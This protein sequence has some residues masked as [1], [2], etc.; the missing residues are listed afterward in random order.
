LGG[1]CDEN[2]IGN[3]GESCGGNDAQLVRISVVYHDAMGGK[4]VPRAVLFDLKPDVIGAL[5]ASPLG[6]L[7]CLGNF[8]NRNAARATTGPR[9]TKQALDTH[10]SESPCCVAA[11]VVN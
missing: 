4:Y 10:Y 6:R 2:G 1:G 3:D 8:V 7:L 9:A 11:F 5:R